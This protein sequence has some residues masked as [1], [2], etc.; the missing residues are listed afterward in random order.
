MT[1]EQ[2]EQ[3]VRRAQ[4]KFHT[5][6]VPILEPAVLEE[7]AAFL[8]F[9]GTGGNPVNLITQERQNGGLYLRYGSASLYVDPGPGAIVHA[10][11]ARLPL[12]WL[13]TLFVSHGHTDH[14]LGAGAIVEAMCRLMRERR[15]RLLLPGS[16]LASGQIDAYHRGEMPSSAYPGGPAVQALVDGQPISLAGGAILTPVRTDHGIEGYGF[17]FEWRG[18]RLGYTSDTRYV[19]TF[20][21]RTGAARPVEP[22]TALDPTGSVADCNEWIRSA[23]G[24][25][26]LLVANVSFFHLFGHRQLTAVG[27]RHLLRTSRVR[28]CILTHFDPSIGSPH[29]TAQAI[30]TW[31][32][33]ETG[34]ACTAA[35]DG[36]RV[37]LVPEEGS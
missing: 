4:A 34:V 15:G 30:A 1:A 12:S 28:R 35:W 22:G 27:L 16:M 26:D 11:R 29:H 6:R 24:E 18:L 13:D 33:E 10:A 20:R 21:D 2:V 19:R 23:L 25:V 14:Y 36:M 9:L 31:L 37:D 32:Q 3:I 7:G 8:H 17:R 5:D